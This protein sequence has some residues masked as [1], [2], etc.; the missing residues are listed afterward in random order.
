MGHVFTK[1]DATQ[2]EKWLADEKNRAILNLET[3]LMTSMLRPVCGESLLDVGCGTG[4]SIKPYLGRGINLTGLDPSPAML[5]IARE[6]L[7][8]R[9]D[10]HRGY[11]EDLPFSDNAFNHVS[12]FL[13]LE[14][15]NDPEEA[16]AEACRVAKDS[17]FIGILNKHSAYV[18][19]LRLRRFIRPTVYDNARFF[20]IGEVRAMVFNRIGRVP[21]S[22]K[23]A[24][25]FPGSPSGLC[26]QIEVS[27]YLQKN[28]FGAFAGIKA[29]PVPRFQAMPITLKSRIEQNATSGNRVASCSEYHSS[30]AKTEEGNG[31]SS[32]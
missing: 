18:S 16:V 30:R 6:N 7:G 12:L 24:L 21:F 3:R 20:G 19:R 23:T 1:Q 27:D 11:A 32:Q 13:S 29:I 4:E 15:S 26:Y 31:G 8:H 22:W 5:E 2:Y 28:P 25:Q 10:F 9:V 17:V 14:F